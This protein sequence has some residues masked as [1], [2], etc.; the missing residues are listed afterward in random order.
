MAN[1]QRTTKRL[2]KQRK[3]DSLKKEKDSANRNHS[4]AF[5]H[6]KIILHVVVIVLAWFMFSKFYKGNES[7][8]VENVTVQRSKETTFEIN[9][10]SS[11]ILKDRV[12][13]KSK[14]EKISKF[15]DWF[16]E[17]GGYISPSVTL[18]EFVDFGGYGLM[19]VSDN[20]S[21]NQHTSSDDKNVLEPLDELYRIPPSII[22]SAKSVYSMYHGGPRLVHQFQHRLN[23]ALHHYFSSSLVQQDVI[24][25]LHLMVECSLGDHSNLRPYL[26]VLPQDT[27]PRLDTFSTEE[28]SL[29]NDQSLSQMAQDSKRSLQN[30]WNEGN[31]KSLVLEMSK[32]AQRHKQAANTEKRTCL[33]F[34]SFHKYVSFVSS[35]A[36]VL[37]GTKY[38]APLADF[39]NYAPRNDQ[40]LSQE[41]LSFNLYHNRNE[42]TGVISVRADRSVQAG[43][44]IFEDYGD[45]DNS[46]FL[47]VR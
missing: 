15:L 23:M 14:D 8:I 40:R 41:S 33:D 19:A 13:E 35:R 38:L 2:K 27:I 24:I 32:S 31:L 39:M 28:L 12:T 29:L 1:Q 17:N 43:E 6:R 16:T 5:L 37:R 21:N 11:E 25:A 42:A 10:Q 47:E 46:L 36:M 7:E 26:D 45:V 22:T 4:S 3:N 30:G 44:Q 34:K 20:T 9:H 18:R